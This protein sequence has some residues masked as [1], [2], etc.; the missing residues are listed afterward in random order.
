MAFLNAQLCPTGWENTLHSTSV[1]R[2]AWAAGDRNHAIRNAK[3]LPSQGQNPHHT[4]PHS[5]IWE[6]RH[7]FCDLIWIVFLHGLT[8][9]QHYLFNLV[10]YPMEKYFDRNIPFLVFMFL[11]C[12]MCC[13]SCYLVV[14]CA[15][16][17]LPPPCWSWWSNLTTAGHEWC[18][19]G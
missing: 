18:S 12:L 10:Q 3:S 6:V 11:N 7:L 1:Q 4:Q 8:C 13:V 5:L 15:Q 2:L 17:H 16:D 9:T 14:A 19:G